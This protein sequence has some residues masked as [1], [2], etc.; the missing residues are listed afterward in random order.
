MRA[1]RRDLS[2]NLPGAAFLGSS[3]RVEDAH[4]DDRV[5]ES[6]GGW[7]TIA[8]GLAER[9]RLQ[10]ILVDDGQ[11]EGLPRSAPQLAPIVDVETG[12]LG[13]GRIE[14]D[15][16]FDAPCRSENLDRLKRDGLSRDREGELAA[17][18]EIEK[19]AGRPV[20]AECRVTI[21]QTDDSDRIRFAQE[22]AGH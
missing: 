8:D 14:R 21:E 10:L 6:V 2:G 16:D 5:I 9:G 13:R 12:R 19:A 17:V 7:D 1:A 4:V 15:L 3:E 18:A 22:P 11:F 20:R